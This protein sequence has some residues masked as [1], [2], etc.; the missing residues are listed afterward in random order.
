MVRSSSFGIPYFQKTPA[1]QTHR[2]IAR[3]VRGIPT[4]GN[5]LA[6][7]MGQVHPRGPH[8]AA[9]SSQPVSWPVSRAVLPISAR[10]RWPCCGARL[11][12]PTRLGRPAGWPKSSPPL[13]AAAVGVGRTG[14]APGAASKSSSSRVWLLTCAPTL[15]GERAAVK[16]LL[17]NTFLSPGRAGAPSSMRHDACLWPHC[18][19]R[20]LEG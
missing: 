17:T 15:G 1:A 18:Q 9:G 4:S 2:A 14:R 20:L 8:G 5:R 7:S 13:R 12:R 16:R 11:P 6:A 10:S 3:G 19:Q